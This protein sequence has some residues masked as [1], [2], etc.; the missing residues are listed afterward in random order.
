MDDPV[1]T[2]FRIAEIEHDGIV[3]RGSNQAPIGSCRK[4]PITLTI[5]SYHPPSF[6][7]AESTVLDQPH[8]LGYLRAHFFGG[9]GSLTGAGQIAGAEASHQS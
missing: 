8:E 3:A 1:A 2:C 4:I 5:L 9:D 7:T 6:P